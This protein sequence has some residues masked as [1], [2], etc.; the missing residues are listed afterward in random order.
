[1]TRVALVSLFQLV[2]A[3]HLVSVGAA[4]AGDWQLE[5]LVPDGRDPFRRPTPDA[6]PPVLLH[7]AFAPAD[8]A[9]VATPCADD[10][11]ATL[12]RI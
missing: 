7:R 11:I 5:V 6:L 1:M 10:F 9:G 8:C 3:A 4:C 12:D 2:N